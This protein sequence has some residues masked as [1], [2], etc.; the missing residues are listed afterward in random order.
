MSLQ[1]CLQCYI[2]R[3]SNRI[4]RKEKEH[5]GLA[6]EQ[7]P[8]FLAMA[9]DD[10]E[11]GKKEIKTMRKSWVKVAKKRTKEDRAVAAAKAREEASGTQNAIGKEEEKP[12][13]TKKARLS[14]KQRAKTGPTKKKEEEEEEEE[15]AD[16]EAQADFF[17]EDE[18]SEED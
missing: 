10:E 16:E 3:K 1:K 9:E 4:C 6:Y 17:G 18:E 2:E 14:K 15:G 8:K 5:T 12:K 13:S 11:D 7:D